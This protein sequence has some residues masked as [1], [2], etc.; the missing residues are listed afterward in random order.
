MILAVPEAQWQKDFVFLTPNSYVHDYINI[1]SP[2]GNTITMDG[3]PIPMSE[4][5]SVPGSDRIAYQ[6]EVSDGVHTVEAAENIS[7][8]VYG[9]DASVSYGY[10]AALGL[11]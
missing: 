6:V 1:V 3:T 5:V 7:I 9:Y 2:P 11:K 4:F 8:V 10:P